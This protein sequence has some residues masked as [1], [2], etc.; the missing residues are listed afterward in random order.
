MQITALQVAKDHI[1]NIG[2]PEPAAR[3]IAVLPVHLQLLKM[4]LHAAIIADSLRISEL[5]DAD[6]EMMGG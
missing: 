3:C 1:G 2:P 6:I 4:L 5:V